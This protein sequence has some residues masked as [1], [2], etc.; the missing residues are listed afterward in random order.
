MNTLEN[1]RESLQQRLA[2]DRSRVLVS[3]P[4]IRRASAPPPTLALPP[5]PGGSAQ[6]AA[7][8][9]SGLTVYDTGA[10]V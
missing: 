2:S 4:R 1:I 3:T 5:P 6:D 9:G 10:S 7:C 8:I